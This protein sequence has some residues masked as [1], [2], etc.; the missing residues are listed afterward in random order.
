[1]YVLSELLRSFLVPRA[2][3]QIIAGIILGLPIFSQLIFTSE[4]TALAKFLADVGVILLLFFVGLQVSFKQ[5]KKNIA[6]SAWISVFNTSI[7]LVLGY[8]AS[9][10]FFS[11]DNS[12]SII[13]GICMSVSA[14]AIALDLLE[15][16]K[17]LRTKLGALIL[18]AGTF[19]DMVEMFL[20]T[21]VLTF[22]ETT[23]KQ[24][25]L[26]Q[27]LYGVILFAG[28]VMIFRFWVIPFVIKRIEG[29]PEHAQ[30]FTGALII[31]LVMAV[32]ADYLGVGAMI[33]ALFSGVVIR[34]ILFKEP[35][36]FP[37]ERTE[38]THSIHT[39]AF[40]FLVPFFFFFI[41]FQTNVLAIWESLGFSIVIT[42]LAIAGTV[43]G[44][45]LGYRM[46]EASWKEGWFVGWAMNAKGD[47]GLII[48]QL[49]LSAGVITSTIFSSLIFMA[50][51]STLVSPLVLRQLIK[52]M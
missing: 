46:V 7:P 32:L 29:Q 27:L 39:I 10:Y 6:T 4:S 9:R 12:T 23:I 44:S 45:A 49:A 1:M 20:I 41:G 14:T 25:T 18:S 13:V 2:V 40:G 47:T 26:T 19:D 34:Q 50:I 3:S 22:L 42:L 51:V 17:K 11:L 36:H 52:K 37:W 5:F 35:G 16:F 31:T 8:L 15:E 38:I 28:I 43:I 48:A 24:T 33:G 21:G 30:L